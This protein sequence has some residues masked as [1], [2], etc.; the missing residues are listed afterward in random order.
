MLS[1]P[2]LGIPKGRKSSEEAAEVNIV[3]HFL[4]FYY[5]FCHTFCLHKETVGSKMTVE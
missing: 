1:S 3:T 4:Y 5:L 2:N